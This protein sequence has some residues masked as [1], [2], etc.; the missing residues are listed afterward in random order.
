M[1]NKLELPK[2]KELANKVI[3]AHHIERTRSIDAGWMGTIF[4]FS[5]EKPGNIAGFAIVL[6]FLAIIGVLIFMPD[7]S[8]FTKKDAMGLFGGI[9]T[10]ALGFLFGRATNGNS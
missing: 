8:S 10:L 7:S 5:T 3:E 1:T 9:I 6:S 2:D 4:G